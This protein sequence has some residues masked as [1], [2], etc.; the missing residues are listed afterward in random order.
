M[1][2]KEYY[3]YK[4]KL[5]LQQIIIIGIYMTICLFILLNTSFSLIAKWAVC[6][7]FIVILYYL[8]K[9]YYYVFR[10]IKS[11]IPF[12]SQ[13]KELPSY[14]RFLFVL[15]ATPFLQLKFFKS[16]GLCAW[17]IAP[18]NTNGKKWSNLNH[19]FKSMYMIQNHSG[20]N[21]VY[22]EISKN[23]KKATKMI[24][25]SKTIE[26][27]PKKENWRTLC[28]SVENN[29]FTINKSLA[30]IKICKDD[31]VISKI[32]KGVMPLNWQKHFSPNTPIIEFT[33]TMNERDFFIC[34]G[35]LIY[36][37]HVYYD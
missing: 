27:Y 5:Y 12:D 13:E 28:F 22:I 29:Q 34:I 20:S 37:Y 15:S 31:Q 35:L 2:I 14:D 23:K 33:E 1:N 25:P 30:T 8:I 4:T 11:S 26:M 7:L 3:S 32:T 9:Y 10:E 36:L 21:C 24:L 19:T 16:N 17:K 6:L 18:Y